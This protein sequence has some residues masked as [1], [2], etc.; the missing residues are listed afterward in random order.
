MPFF[1][2]VFADFLQTSFGIYKNSFGLSLDPSI[3]LIKR[4]NICCAILFIGEDIVVKE[5]DMSADK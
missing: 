5:G 1:S 4:F 3:L 2:I